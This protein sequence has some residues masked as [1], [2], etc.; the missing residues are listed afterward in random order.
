[1]LKNVM[2]V[3]LAAGSS[4]A[5]AETPQVVEF[6]QAQVDHIAHIY[7]HA[8][9]GER[10]ITLQSDGQTSPANTGSSVPVW[11]AQSTAICDNGQSFSDSFFFAINPEDTLVEI[12]DIATDT[13]VDCIQVNWITSYQDTD[14]DSDG[15]GD[16]IEELGG[17]WIVWDADDGRPNCTRTPVMAVTLFNLPGSLEA[18]QTVKY[19]VDIDLVA[20]FSGTDLSFEIG[21]TDGDCQTAAYCNSSVDSNGTPIGQADNNFDGLPDSDLDGDGLFDWTWS[22]RF[23]HPGMGY[24]LDSDGDTGVFDPEGEVGIALGVPLGMSVDQGDGS[25]AWEIDT[26]VEAAGFGV[27]DRFALYRNGIYLGGFWFGGFSCTTAPNGSPGYTPPAMFQFE[28][29]G[30]SVVDYIC[31]DYNMDGI[32]NFFDI[33]YFISL[34]GS[35]SPTADLN[36]DGEWNFFDISLFLNRQDD[37]G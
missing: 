7:Y 8:G 22:V 24:D 11:S 10:V 14:T 15:T 33:S 30:P 12:A 9:N 34:Y 32:C 21:D 27:E 31:C 18:G 6:N 1:M 36:D 35:Q 5:T 25:W 16:G 2:M 37:C 13:V 23:F 17:Q 20:G 28:M 29:L 26:S 3:A 4:C 19:T